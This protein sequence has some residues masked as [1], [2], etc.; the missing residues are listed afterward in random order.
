MKLLELVQIWKKRMQL[1][2]SY[3]KYLAEM[4]YWFWGV[5]IYDDILTSQNMPNFFG[6]ERYDFYYGDKMYCFSVIQQ[7]YNSLDFL[8]LKQSSN[9]EA[10][11]LRH[12]CVLRRQ[13]PLLL[14]EQ[15][16]MCLTSLTENDT[17]STSEIKFIA[18][19]LYNNT[20]TLRIS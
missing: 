16:K 7:Y 10:R 15:A 2:A 11:T 3:C 12:T 18:F 17:I 14:Y 9:W 8:I 20:I 13:T 19:Q 6:W 1:S 4:L 5:H